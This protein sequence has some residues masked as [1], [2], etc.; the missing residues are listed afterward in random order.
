M[1]TAWITLV[2][3]AEG[4]IEIQYFEEGGGVQARKFQKPF[5]EITVE[6]KVSPSRST[7]CS[8]FEP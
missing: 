7:F 1:D 4:S 5:F 8:G 2:L 6:P 3:S